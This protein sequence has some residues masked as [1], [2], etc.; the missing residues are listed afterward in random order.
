VNSPITEPLLLSPNTA[1]KMLDVSRST[2]YMLMKNGI[3]S[4]VQMGA[5][6]RIPIEEVKR[7]AAEGAP[8]ITKRELL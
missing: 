1:A 4:F 2:V 6:R 5:D 3:L 7:V 8:A